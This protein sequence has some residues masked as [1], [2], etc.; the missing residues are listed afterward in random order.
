MFL[1]WVLHK[2]LSETIATKLTIAAL[3]QVLLEGLWRLEAGRLRGNANAFT[4]HI[5]FKLSV[6]SLHAP[7]PHFYPIRCTIL[8]GIMEGIIA[9]KT[10]P[11]FLPP[12]FSLRWNITMVFIDKNRRLFTLVAG[13]RNYEFLN[14]LFA[15]V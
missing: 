10:R 7:P 4:M 5:N 8:E 13:G 3:F 15:S 11:T 12:C 6:E 1:N 14:E 2:F 9:P